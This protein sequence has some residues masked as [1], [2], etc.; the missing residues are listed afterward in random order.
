MSGMAPTD[1]LERRPLKPADSAR[2]LLLSQEAAWNQTEQDWRLMIRLGEAVGMWTPEERLV[3]TALMLPFGAPF[4]WIS[5][6]I[7]ARDHRHRGIATDLLQH[8]QQRLREKGLVAGLDATEAGRPVYL[9]LGFQDVY[10]LTRMFRKTAV[11]PVEPVAPPAGTEIV[12]MKREDL[13][14]VCAFDRSGFGGDRSAILRHLWERR[15]GIAHV[16]R[17]GGSLVGYV[18]GRDGREAAYVGPLLAKSADVAVVLADRA[19]AVL[20]EPAFMDVPDAQA[21]LLGW[22]AERGFIRQR[23]YSRMYDGRSRPFDT[24]ELVFAIAGPELG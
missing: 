6:V 20:S 14:G 5:M 15:P 8:C 3:A 19:L 1:P 24:P 17:Q 21:P 2:A 11:S 16:A 18:L 22:L 13:A 10:P 12:P 9:P 23:G 7:V 4:A